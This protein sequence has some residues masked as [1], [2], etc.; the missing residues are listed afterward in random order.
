MRMTS[1]LDTPS[2]IKN[3]SGSETRQVLQRNVALYPADIRRVETIQ[4]V[5]ELDSFSKAMRKAIELA[6]DQLKETA[7]DAA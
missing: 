6:M 2:V 5:Y 4:T 7:K 3:R 1:L